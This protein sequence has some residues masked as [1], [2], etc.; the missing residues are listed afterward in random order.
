MVSPSLVGVVAG[1]F[2]RVL[3]ADVTNFPILR[4]RLQVG[5]KLSPCP[6][7]QCKRLL[8]N[9]VRD[10]RHLQLEDLRCSGSSTRR[11]ETTTKSS[12]S[13]AYTTLNTYGDGVRSHVQLHKCTPQR[14]CRQKR[15]GASPAMGRVYKLTPT[16]GEADLRP[17]RLA[18]GG[19]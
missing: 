5:C 15:G 10:T 18:I 8:S 6:L 17:R 2:V 3:T 4:E 9:R 12:R 11:A 19:R 16:A 13:I 7:F 1:R 14:V